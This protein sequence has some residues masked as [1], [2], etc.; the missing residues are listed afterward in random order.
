MKSTL[1]ISMKEYWTHDVMSTMTQY[2]INLYHK[3]SVMLSYFKLNKKCSKTLHIYIYIKTGLKSKLFLTK[4]NH[5]CIV[6]YKRNNANF[7]KKESFT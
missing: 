1:F 4:V 7:R 2:K 5:F 6:N 3:L